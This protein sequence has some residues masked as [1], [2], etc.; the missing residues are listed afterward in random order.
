[1]TT[2]IPNAW[3]LWLADLF[4]RVA[5]EGYGIAHGA[6]F[7]AFPGMEDAAADRIEQ[8]SQEAAP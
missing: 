5:D 7:H 6:N 8:L 2:P 4:A 1:M 3:R